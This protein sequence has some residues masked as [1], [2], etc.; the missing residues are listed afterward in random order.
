MNIDG[1]TKEIITDKYG[2]FDLS[3]GDVKTSINKIEIAKE[4]A[5]HRILSSYKDMFKYPNYGANIQ[6]SIGKKINDRTISVLCSDI[7]HSLTEDFFLGANEVSILPIEDGHT[8][9]LKINVGENKNALY[10]KD[11]EINISIN[12]I[13]GVTYVR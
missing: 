11:S 7:S 1:V 10:G 12:T 8:V 6:E 9:H 13:E 4:N 3:S 2:D 5:H